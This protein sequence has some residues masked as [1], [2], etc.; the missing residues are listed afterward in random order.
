MLKEL[1]ENELN[2]A[3]TQKE[4]QDF[5]LF[6]RFLIES[7]AKFNLTA[8][9]IKE[10]VYIKH[11]L[12]SCRAL[13]FLCQGASLLDVGSG[14]GFP[15]IPLAITRPDLKITAL[16]SNAKK[17]GFV[18]QSAKLLNLNNLTVLCQRAE[19]FAQREVFDITCSRATASASSLLEVLAPLTKTGGKI[20]LY[21]GKEE[22]SFAAAQKALL[23]NDPLEIKYTLPL[24]GQ[25]RLLIFT[26]TH[27]T[28]II[29]PRPNGKP[30]KKPL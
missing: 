30:F 2:L 6:Y 7:N 4:L 26:K 9:T 19:D 1:F 17:C 25:R 27:L 18:L 20:I 23:L 24:Y 21:K 11:F 3:L 15:A 16:D 14:G 5:E 10:E 13:P 8:I 12:D 28:P 22:E 29:Y